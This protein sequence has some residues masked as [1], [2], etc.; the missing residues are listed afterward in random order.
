MEGR[1]DLAV[2]LL[3]R[4][5][6]VAPD[7]GSALESLGLAYLMAGNYVD[8]E[9]VLR[10]ALALPGAPPSVRMRLGAALLHQG[11]HGAAIQELERVLSLDPADATA[12]LNLGQAYAGAGRWNEAARAFERVLEN[13]PRHSD[14]LF[15]L[16]VA[17]SEQRDH[18][19]ARS[20]FE[21]L[22]GLDARNAD[23]RER[24]ASSCFAVGRYGEA[25]T[26]LREL[27]R[28]RPGDSALHVALAE[29]CFEVGALDRAQA[30]A[31]RAVELDRSAAG[32][33][34]VLARLHYVRGELDH[35]IEALEDAGEA[36]DSGPLLGLLFHLLHRVCDWPK[37]RAAWEKAAVAIET[38]ADVGSP[39]S[40]L[41]EETTPAQQLV[42]TRRWAAARFASIRAAEPPRPV[43]ADKPDRRLRV[44]YF[45][46]DF[47]DHAIGHLIIEVL[48]L[49]D[50]RSFEIFAYSYGPDDG[51][52]VRARLRSGVEHFVDVS[53]ETDDAIVARM[54]ADA[55]DLL[56]D[57][58]GYTVGDRLTVMAH[59]PCAVQ[60]TWLGYP[61]TSGADFIDYVIA[62]GYI[63]PEA[64]EAFYSERVL[65]MPLCY[66]PNDRKRPILSPG[67][68][69]QYGLPENSFVF[70]CFNQ[71]VKILPEVFARWMSLLRR[72]PESVLWLLEDNR[73]AADNLKRAAADEGIDPAR[74]I[75]APRLPNE[76]H[77]AR[78]GAADLALDT[79]PYTSHTTASDG[80][81]MG[82]PLVALCGETFAARVSASIVS[83]AGFPDLV[84]HS[85]EEYEA[86]AF[87]LATDRAA[88][89][90]IRSRLSMA[91]REAPLF[92]SQ[93]FARDLEDLYLDVVR[94]SA[95]SSPTLLPKGEG[96][97]SPLPSG[98]G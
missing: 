72:V 45:S 71:A 64:A 70:C 69:S 94:R 50:S 74:L 13:D 29:A 75:L 36:A 85:L 32:A 12:R 91:R 65:R 89:G 46:S 23:A 19:R 18:E 34:S 98:E 24:L 17:S 68:R 62:D 73:W 21:R 55:L 27:V 5:V 82:C 52:A 28:L 53:R 81:W 20:C 96:R 41:C 84:T 95:P 48:E 9:R 11:E 43:R 25:C 86:L 54:R 78:F 93:K 97:Q 60:L 7:R 56:V 88:L 30:A 10:K 39:F 15:N 80:L 33:Y 67:P 63:I 8:A 90:D 49:H 3:E 22:L 1:V 47:Q 57:L 4:T 87:R 66:Q 35:A 44:G 61:G 76:E 37:W 6:A 92:D 40:L 77:L 42:Y 2:P 58:K 79:F 14:A 51:S 83:G 26:H 31:R 16:G 59:R 38:S